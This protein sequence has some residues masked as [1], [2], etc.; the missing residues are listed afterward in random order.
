MTGTNNPNP[1]SNLTNLCNKYN[2][3]IHKKKPVKIISNLEQQMLLEY[4]KH[5][6]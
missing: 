5:K 6:K 3:A 4:M 1:S 2:D